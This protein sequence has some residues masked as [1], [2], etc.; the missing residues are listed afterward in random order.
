MLRASSPLYGVSTLSDAPTRRVLRVLLGARAPQNWS[1]QCTFPREFTNYPLSL[2]GP[3]ASWAPA[4]LL[5]QAG[6]EKKHGGIEK[7]VV[8]F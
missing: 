2:V 6:F 5:K 8:A 3:P 4:A 7:Y 1:S